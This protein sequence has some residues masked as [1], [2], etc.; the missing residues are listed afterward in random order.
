[1]LHIKET[2]NKNGEES[3]HYNIIPVGSNLYSKLKIPFTSKQV[4]LSC[5]LSQLSGTFKKLIK[6]H[7]SWAT[8]RSETT[9]QTS[10]GQKQEKSKEIEFAEKQQIGAHLWK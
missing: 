7:R 2:S 1:M 3:I 10:L 6:R 8:I 9:R 4:G 5:S